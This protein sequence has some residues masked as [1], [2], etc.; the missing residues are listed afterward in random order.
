MGIKGK[1]IWPV[2]ALGWKEKGDKN[3]VFK[4]PMCLECVE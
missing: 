2:V 4:M 3:A 1:E